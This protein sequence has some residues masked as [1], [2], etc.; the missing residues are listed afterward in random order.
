[1][2]IVIYRAFD[3]EPVGN[4]VGERSWRIRFTCVCPGEHKASVNW[5]P[6]DS[7]LQDRGITIVAASNENLQETQRRMKVI[8]SF[9]FCIDKA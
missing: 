7:F 1:M 5:S 6:A 8:V 9:F 4:K 2:Q 3:V